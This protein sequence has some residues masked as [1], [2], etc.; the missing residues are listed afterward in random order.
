MPGLWLYQGMQV[1]A[2]TLAASVKSSAARTASSFNLFRYDVFLPPYE[3]L[4][5]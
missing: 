3:P 5:C 4:Q 2:T 1:R